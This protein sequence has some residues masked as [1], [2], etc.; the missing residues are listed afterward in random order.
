MQQ[1]SLPANIETPKHRSRT[2]PDGPSAATY[3]VPEAAR[4]ARVGSQAI[5][6]GIKAGRIPHVKFGRS[7]LIPK[8]AFL[9]WLDQCGGMQEAAQ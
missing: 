1:Q 8:S 3:K 7:I 6:K 4:I 9:R 5:R 2:I